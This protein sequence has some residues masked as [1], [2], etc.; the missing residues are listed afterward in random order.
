MVHYVQHE[1]GDEY[2]HGYRID[3]YHARSPRIYALGG[4]REHEAV[5]GR[6]DDEQEIGERGDERQKPVR[7]AYVIALCQ[8]HDV[9]EE[10]NIEIVEENEVQDIR[11]IVEPDGHVAAA[12]LAVR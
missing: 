1:V 5:E 7:A 8:R 10:H 11:E 9:G 3:D 12:R 4:D 2:R 6:G